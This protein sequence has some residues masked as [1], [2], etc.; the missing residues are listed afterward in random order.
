MQK[1]NAKVSYSSILTAVAIWV[2]ATL[3]EKGVLRKS[4]TIFT[5][6]DKS[7]GYLSN[8]WLK[9]SAKESPCL[10]RSGSWSLLTVVSFNNLT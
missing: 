3:F 7:P 2:Y 8:V 6:F 9:F 1:I 10:V 5:F 4:N